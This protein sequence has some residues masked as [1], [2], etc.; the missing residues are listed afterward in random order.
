MASSGLWGPDIW[1]SP[2]SSL[3][4]FPSIFGSK[5]LIDIWIPLIVFMITIGHIPACV[6]N[7]AK[8]RRSKNLPL[9]PLFLEWTPFLVFELST[10]AWL[11]SPYSTLLRENRLVLFCVTMSFVFGR[12][13]TKIILAHL[14][15]QPFPYWTV[16]L[17][18]LIGGAILVN[19]P[20]LL[21]YEPVS[22]EVELWYLRAY[23]VFATI[24][25]F[26]WAFRV[27]N[28]ICN[29]LDINCLTITKRLLPKELGGEWQD[30]GKHQA[31]GTP[32][33]RSQRIKAS[34]NGDVKGE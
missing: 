21:G 28:S 12:M 6:Y 2:I 10:A 5:S 32:S 13:T 29:Y 14:T 19:L 24:V 34:A 4:G 16:Q 18:P 15:R 3:V 11:Y 7:V 9:A 17:Y 23:F 33:R 25:Y 30:E 20:P 8:A 22:A 26:T 31:N 1:H 27:I